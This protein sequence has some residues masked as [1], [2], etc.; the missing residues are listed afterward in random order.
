MRILHKLISI[1][2]VIHVILSTLSIHLVYLD[3]EV[4]QDYIANVL[5]INKEEPITICDGK[6]YLNMKLE[7]ASE[8]Q[9]QE[10]ATNV[11]QLEISF[12]NQPITTPVITPPPLATSVRHTLTVEGGQINPFLDGVFRPPQ[13]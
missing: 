6:C 5:C 3:F 4:R 11:R 7:E 8:K 9:D 2:L 13:C 10:N 1:Y 12:F